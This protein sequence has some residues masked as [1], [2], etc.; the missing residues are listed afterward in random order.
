[1]EHCKE[2]Y[3]SSSPSHTDP[4]LPLGSR[5][6]STDLTA[7]YGKSILWVFCLGSGPVF[8]CFCVL[9]FALFFRWRNASL[10]GGFAGRRVLLV[11]V[12]VCYFNRFA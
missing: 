5:A 2:A 10:A 6:Y 12:V 11:F 9:L 8:C 1:M 4:A 7:S 3:D